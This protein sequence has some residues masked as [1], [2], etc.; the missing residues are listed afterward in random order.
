[1][2][3]LAKAPDQRFAT[4]QAMSMALQHATAHLPPEQWTPITASGTHRAMP[5]G[6]QHTPPATWGGNRSRAV[7]QQPDNKFLGSQST[8]SASSG[9][10]QQQPRAPE[11]KSRKIEIGS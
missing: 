8:V 2:T 9:Q 6:W 7:S 5:S 4:A 10:V 11:K 1:M 3:A